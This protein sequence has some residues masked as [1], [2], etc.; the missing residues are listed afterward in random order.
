MS[1]K[2]TFHSKLVNFDI[3]S[4]SNS[5][6]FKI[7]NAWVVNSMK[8]PPKYLN[9]DKVKHSKSHLTDIDFRNIDVD[10]DILIM[11]GADTL[12]FTYTRIYA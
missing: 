4:N 10:S 9:L 12:C 6:I 5:E 7:T 1:N 2:K 8:L 3:S 11:I